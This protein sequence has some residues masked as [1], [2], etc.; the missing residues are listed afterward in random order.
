MKIG[1]CRGCGA[2]IVWIRTAGGKNMPCDPERI[3]YRQR[4]GAAGKIVAPNGEVLSCDV[5]VEPEEATGAG[6]IS[7]FSTC[8]QAQK[9]RRN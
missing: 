4:N 5:G 3:L 6:Y 8:P 7:H 2:P 9:F 1:K